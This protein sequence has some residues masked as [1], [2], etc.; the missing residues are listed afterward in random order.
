MRF[1]REIQRLAGARNMG[2]IQRKQRE[3]R[4]NGE[5]LRGHIQNAHAGEFQ[6][7]CRACL[8][9]KEK[10]MEVAGCRVTADGV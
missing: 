7:D 6:T 5:A 3:S 10:L 1:R 8:E 9:L 4:A 2:G